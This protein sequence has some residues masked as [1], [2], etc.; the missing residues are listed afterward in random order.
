MRGTLA[1][2]TSM[3]LFLLDW[4][5]HFLKNNVKM[6]FLQF[7]LFE[8]DVPSFEHA[9]SIKLLKRSSLS[10]NQ[11]DLVNFIHLQHCLWQ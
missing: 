7:P 8:V 1:L 5:S 11:H 2:P 10:Y 4:L 6:R 3:S 9:T